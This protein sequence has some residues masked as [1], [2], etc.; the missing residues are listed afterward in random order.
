MS[1]LYDV[2]AGFSAEKLAVTHSLGPGDI[3]KIK[4][5]GGKVRVPDSITAAHMAEAVETQGE[6]DDR[7]E[8]RTINLLRVAYLNTVKNNGVAWTT[9][10]S[11]W[12]QK[13]E[14]IMR[15]KIARGGN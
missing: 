3:R 6:Q 2:P 15:R 10:E 12:M 4:R 11:N 1:K 5:D 13:A 7:R 14:Q 9:K 8:E